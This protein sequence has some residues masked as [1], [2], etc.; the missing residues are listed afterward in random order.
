ML[1]GN[2]RGSQRGGGG[3]GGGIQGDVFR[4][5]VRPHQQ[6]TYVSSLLTANALN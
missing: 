4:P 1:S 6:H 2:V 5:L 3:G